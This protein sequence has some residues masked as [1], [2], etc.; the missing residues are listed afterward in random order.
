MIRILNL[1]VLILNTFILIA[2]QFSNDITDTQ[3][4]K[5]LIYTYYFT[6]LINSN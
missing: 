3:E 2:G 6:H 1:L 4:Y 5:N